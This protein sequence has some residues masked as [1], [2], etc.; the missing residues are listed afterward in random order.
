MPEHPRTLDP[1]S[2]LASAKDW[3]DEAAAEAAMRKIYGEIVLTLPLEAGRIKG[4][5]LETHEQRR[6]GGSS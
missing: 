2:P 6:L 5:K 4:G 1:N 3:L